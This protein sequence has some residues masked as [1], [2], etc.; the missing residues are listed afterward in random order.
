MQNFTDFEDSIIKLMLLEDEYL[1]NKTI[2]TYLRSKEIEVDA[3]LEGFD[4]LDSIGNDYD[5]FILDIDIPNINGLE[6]LEEIRS[7]YPEVP[8]IMISATIDMGMITKAYS[9]GCSD[10]LKKPFD[11]KELELKIRAFTRSVDNLVKITTE[12]TYDKENKEFHY[13]K[14]LI[15]LT[16]KE[17]LFFS[18]LLKNRGHIMS[19]EKLEYLLWN[20]KESSGHLRQLVNRF[21]KKIPEQ[22]IY[23]RV[24]EGYIL[25]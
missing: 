21:R 16:Q 14:E 15:T 19:H 1:L 3:F 10:Y 2:Q 7:S 17:A 22:I 9:L 5:L 6:V 13:K 8:V 11:I 20:E 18:I 12:L 23:N 24:N 25:P 4:A